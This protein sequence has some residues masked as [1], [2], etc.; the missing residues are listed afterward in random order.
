MYNLETFK[1]ELIPLLTFNKPLKEF[2]YSFMACF[3]AYKM[4]GKNFSSFEQWAD[5][6]LKDA[7]LQIHGVQ[8]KSK[9]V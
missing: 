5:H 4:Y 2:H 1:K 3:I 8:L 9:Q 6:C 7:D